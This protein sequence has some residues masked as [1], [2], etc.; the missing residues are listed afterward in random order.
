MGKEGGAGTASPGCHGNLG[1][2]PPQPLL[3]GGGEGAPGTRSDASDRGRRQPWQ[4]STLG[5]RLNV[6]HGAA[7]QR[8]Q[9][10][11][12]GR[13]SKYLL[14]KW[15]KSKTKGEACVVRPWLFN[16]HVI[17]SRTTSPCIRFVFR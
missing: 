15:R 3:G 10:A 14:I 11:P 6:E 8:P 12:T 16:K 5:A 17:R 9:P 13:G 1:Q 4:N 2:Q 7:A